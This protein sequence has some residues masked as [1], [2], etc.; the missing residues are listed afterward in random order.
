MTARKPRA[1][2]S[3]ERCAAVLTIKNVAQMTPRG[4]RDVCDWLRR[5]IGHVE[6]NPHAFA[7]KY[8]AR[9]IYSEGA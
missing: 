8:C 9:F 6:Q 3:T 5:Q 7:G 2:E 1:A 4:R